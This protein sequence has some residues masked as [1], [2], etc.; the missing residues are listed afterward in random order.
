[1]TLWYIDGWD[2]RGGRAFASQ[3]EKIALTNHF[4]PNNLPECIGTPA[5][6]IGP[7][8]FQPEIITNPS[9]AL[10]AARAGFFDPRLPIDAEE[11]IGF[12][13]AQAVA[14]F[15]R[16]AFISG[17]GGRGG[18]GGTP[19]AE[20]GPGEPPASPN[21]EY[22]GL[23]RYCQL[24]NSQINNTSS[25][26]YEFDN[27]SMLE[28]N[29]VNGQ[30]YDPVLSGALQVA[31]TL[32]AAYPRDWADKSARIWNN[33]ASTLD[34]A[35]TELEIWNDL[36]LNKS[37]TIPLSGQLEP[38]LDREIAKF[39]RAHINNGSPSQYFSCEI[40]HILLT[41]RPA[42]FRNGDIDLSRWLKY[43]LD[44]FPFDF[45]YWAVRRS[46]L[47]GNYRD[48]FEPM[49]SWP[50][51]QYAKTEYNVQNVGELLVKF[52]SSPGQF[53]NAN[54]ATL[55]IIQFAA[56]LL[57]CGVLNRNNSAWRMRSAS[58]W[59]AQSLPRLVFS[60]QIEDIIQKVGIKYK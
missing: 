5:I 43:R 20:G 29:S 30:D 34:L 42:Y 23:V 31:V 55:E 57:G 13:S 35:M 19:V 18:E 49:F 25:E 24:F 10:S 59:L 3:R 51:P 15:V 48:R 46:G 53:A 28:M 36:L 54:S 52:V 8:G 38:W 45:P 33:A 58:C 9:V 50:L 56:A 12:P 14:E 11:E 27:L 21:M 44:G 32:L 7:P 26:F 6:F 1:M 4:A 60:E 22:D 40:L 17:G 2:A 47:P 39:W 16:R 37:R 41:E